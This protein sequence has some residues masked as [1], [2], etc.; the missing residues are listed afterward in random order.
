M[1]SCIAVLSGTIKTWKRSYI[2]SRPGYCYCVRKSSHSVSFPFTVRGAVPGLIPLHRQLGSVGVLFGRD[3]FIYTNQVLEQCKQCLRWAAQLLYEQ[4]CFLRSM[5]ILKKT[6][7]MF[8]WLVWD[9]TT[10]S[11]FSSVPALHYVTLYSYV[12]YCAEL[13][14][15]RSGEYF[16]LNRSFIIKSYF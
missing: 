10:Q 4:V 16:P 15:C 11:L 1:H 6:W 9:K 14:L 5:L 7:K 2:N 8:I 13:V 3:M 12:V